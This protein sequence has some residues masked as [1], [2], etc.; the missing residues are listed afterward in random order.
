MSVAVYT[1]LRSART[2]QGTASQARQIVDVASPS[3][4][5]PEVLLDE[6]EEQHSRNAAIWDAYTHGRS[7]YVSGG[8]LEQCTSPAERAGYIGAEADARKADL[9]AMLAVDFDE[10]Q[11]HRHEYDDEW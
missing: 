1:R 7:R 6:R 4:V 3:G 10:W 11:L 9:R 2:Q 8:T 5:L